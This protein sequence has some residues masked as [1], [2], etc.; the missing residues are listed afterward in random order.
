V[1]PDWTAFLYLIEGQGTIGGSSGKT[2]LSTKTV[3]DLALGGDAVT[4]TACKRGAALLFAAAPPLREP[5]F[6]EAFVMSTQAELDQAMADLRSGKFAKQ[7]GGGGGGS[8][9]GGGRRR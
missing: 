7:V 2:L 9:S 5:I 1:D 4:V 8:G 3:Y 6:A